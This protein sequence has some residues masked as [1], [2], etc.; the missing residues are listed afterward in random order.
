VR[1]KGSGLTD[2]EAAAPGARL[3]SSNDP[4][5]QLPTDRLW[6]VDGGMTVNYATAGAAEYW[7][8]DAGG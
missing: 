6:L 5:A 2:A 4:L 1:S 3:V 7:P 8:G